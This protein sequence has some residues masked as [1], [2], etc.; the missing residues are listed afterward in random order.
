MKSKLYWV[1]FFAFALLLLVYLGGSW[2]FSTV[3][4]AR[5]TSTIEASQE[6][7]ATVDL[8]MLP[9][10]EAVSIANG[11]ISLAGSFY[12]NDDDGDCAVLL[13]HGYTGTRYTAVQYAPLFW[14]RGCD[15]LAYDA[16][17]HGESSDAYHTYGYHEKFDAQAAYT[18]LLNK[19]GLDNTQVGVVGVSYGAATSLQMLPLGTEPAFVVADSPYADLDAIVAYQAVEQFGNWVKLFVP[20]AF[21]ISEVR[22]DFNK[23]EISPE[24]AVTDTAVPILLIH[25]SSDSFTPPV[26]SERIY[27]HTNPAITELHILDWGSPHAKDIF[28]DYDAYK[29][30]VDR[31]LATQQISFG[32]SDG[33]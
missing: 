7:L 13:L 15:V 17:G 26:N 18:W 31:F 21:A 16:R 29:I 20:A 5:E 8:S 1:A 3:L 24:E 22:A 28:T 2:Y 4:L 6:S 9:Q 19:T 12:E 27:T 30:I 23:E 10:P 25:S 33:R 14:E 11:E 32:Q